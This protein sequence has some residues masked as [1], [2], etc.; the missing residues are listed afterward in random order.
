MAR[1]KSPEGRLT[2]LASTN[3]VPISPAP[4]SV[5][6]AQE[7]PGEMAKHAFP[8]MVPP[9]SNM[10]YVPPV[11]E[12]SK[13]YASTWLP[14]IKQS[15]ATGSND[16]SSVEVGTFNTIPPI[17]IEPEVIASEHRSDCP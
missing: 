16:A 6:P 5:N 3:P 14:G 17:G 12:L 7:I 9:D 8:D 4:I 15:A 2:Q 1:I 10:L 13:I 11:A